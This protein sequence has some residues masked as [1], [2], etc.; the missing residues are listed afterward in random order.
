MPFN[1][2]G[3]WIPEKTPIKK[4]SRPIKVIKERRGQSI[5]TI[6]LN[7]PMNEKE[8]KEFCSQLKQQLG[9]GGCV[10]NDAIE[11][12]GEKI[13]QIKKIIKNQHLT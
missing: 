13:E 4:P 3:D 11:L 2:A 12:Q 5:V 7:L 10:K 8:L 9:C 1:I 6:I